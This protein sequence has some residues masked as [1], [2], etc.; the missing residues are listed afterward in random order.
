MSHEPFVIPHQDLADLADLYRS[1][2]RHHGVSPLTLGWTKGKQDIRYDVLL[3]GLECEGS[4]VLDV[5]CGFG[6]LNV[7]LRQRARRYRYVGIDM[8]DELVCEASRLYASENVSFHTGDLLSLPLT[9][10]FTYVLASGIFAYPLTEMDNYAYIELMLRTMLDRCTDAVAVD[11]LSNQVNFRREKT[12]Y[13]DPQR[14]LAIALRLTR[15]VRLRHDYMPFEFCL[16]LFKSD[17]FDEADT[18]FER[19]KHAR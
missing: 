8:V 4:V 5:G 19:Y 7:A 17:V 2:W 13:A 3:S 1:R 11:F 9:E 16:T 18:V 14:I 6:D 10:Q 12:F 15:N